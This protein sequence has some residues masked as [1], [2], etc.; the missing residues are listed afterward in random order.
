M[1]HIKFFII[2]A[3][4]TGQLNPAV[5]HP[6]LSYGLYTLAQ[7]HTHHQLNTELSVGL[8]VSSEACNPVTMHH[9]EAQWR[10]GE[11]SFS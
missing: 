2:T 1:E 8:S 4:C 11:L 7:V 6:L 3:S 10:D 5:G 9:M